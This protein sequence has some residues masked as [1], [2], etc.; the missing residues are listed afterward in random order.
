[1][2][3]HHITPADRLAQ[4]S[5]ALREGTDSGFSMAPS[6]RRQ[7]ANILD[8]IAAELRACQRADAEGRDVADAIRAARTE[9]DLADAWI[10]SRPK[11]L[12]MGMPARLAAIEAWIDAS[13][14]MGNDG[15]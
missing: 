12:G 1:M 8:H 3:T 5:A 11:R 14:R 9:G 15:R 7:W 6:T 10:G 13:S 2:N 4:V